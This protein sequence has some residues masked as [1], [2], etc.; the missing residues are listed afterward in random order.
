MSAGAADSIGEKFLRICEMTD[1]RL[2]A[3]SPAER[4]RMLQIHLT[5]A[6]GPRRNFM[7][8]CEMTDS[9]APIRRE[10]LLREME[11]EEHA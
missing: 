5:A 9:L 6:R 1:E 8:L 3:M 2:R 11:R 7:L 10:R 4:D